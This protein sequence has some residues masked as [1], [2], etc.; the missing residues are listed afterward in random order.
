MSTAL[1][2]AAFCSAS[3]K[4]MARSL[5]SMAA[6]A[7]AIASMEVRARSLRDPAAAAASQMAPSTS[8]RTAQVS[9]LSPPRKRRLSSAGG[10]RCTYAM[11]SAGCLASVRMRSRSRAVDVAGG[12]NALR[13]AAAAAA[14][15]AAG[16][17]PLFFTPLGVSVEPRDAAD[18]AAFPAAAAPGAIKVEA[19]TAATN[20]SVSWR[21]SRAHIRTGARTREA[22]GFR[23]A[24]TR[25][26]RAPS[27]TSSSL[28]R[29]CPFLGSRSRAARRS[30]AAPSQSRMRARASARLSIAFT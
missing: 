4:R 10:M 11:R 29:A 1:R 15:A 21:A 18:G 9:G 20:G 22:A 6:S 12:G 3:K 17:L 19:A 28:A 14:E 25:A 16:P 13:A 7:M 23:V 27:S 24:R 30:A 2:T 5:R 26:S 8:T